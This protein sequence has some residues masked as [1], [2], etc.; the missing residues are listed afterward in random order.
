MFSVIVSKLYKYFMKKLLGK[1]LYRFRIIKLIYDYAVTLLPKDNFEINGFKFNNNSGNLLLTEISNSKE[2]SF[3]NKQIQKNMNVIDIGANIGYYT[4]HLSNLVGSNGTV[5]AFEP[6]PLNFSILEKN[7]KLN[8]CKNVVLINK[9]VSNSCGATTL[10]QNSEN[11]GG[12]SLIN[13]ENIQK[14]ITVD[15]ITLDDYFK[16]ITISIDLVKIDVEGAEDFVI[17]GGLNFFQIFKPKYVITEFELNS[18]TQDK[19]FYPD[20]LSHLNYDLLGKIDY[21]KT[22]SNIIQV[23]IDELK[24]SQINSTVI[25]LIWKYA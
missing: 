3:C 12:H 22:N 6:D 7:V 16:N 23:S 9:A 10:F 17:N 2:I 1:R 25:N 4:V 21:S 8:D 20:I 18:K 5:F 15:T 13:S 14:T 11:S 19:S 24:K